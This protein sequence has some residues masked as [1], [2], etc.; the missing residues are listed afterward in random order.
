MKGI[1]LLRCGMHVGKFVAVVEIVI[2]RYEG[3]CTECGARIY[4]MRCLI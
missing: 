1:E 3:V 4:V 2:W